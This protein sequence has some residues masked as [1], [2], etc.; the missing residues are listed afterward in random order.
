MIQLP[1]SCH[2]AC[3]CVRVCVCVHVFLAKGEKALLY[4][5][6]SLTS[7]WDMPQAPLPE[8]YLFY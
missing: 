5:A 4:C 7:K 8:Q 6:V 2:S 1:K 3:V